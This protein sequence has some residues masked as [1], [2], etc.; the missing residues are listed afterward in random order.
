RPALDINALDE[1]P[2]STW[3]CP[4]NHLHPM[5]PGEVAAGPPAPA[6]R[7]PLRITKGKDQ[8]AA[9]GFQAVD[10]ANH[11]FMVKLP[12]EGHLGMIA[13]G[14]TIGARAFHAAGYNVPGAFVVDLRA[15]DLTVDPDA[16]FNLF[17]V[18]KRPL[19]EARV[20]EMLAGVAHHPDGR[21]RALA[22]P[23]IPGR[24]MG[25]FDMMGVRPGD[26]NDRIPHQH[27]RS[28]RASWVLFAWLSVL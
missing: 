28:L 8:G 14:E 25:S 6:P 13:A 26:P 3:F 23:W 12:P 22:V 7:L 20:R 5:T 11:R 19:T 24:I 4:R 21:L 27:R 2:C 15:Q 17:G 9:S 10:A 16:S 18:E 1:V